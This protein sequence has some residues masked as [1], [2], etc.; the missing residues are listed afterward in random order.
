MKCPLSS[1]EMVAVVVVALTLAD[2]MDQ[3]SSDSKFMHCVNEKVFKVL[4][5][6]ILSSR[7]FQVVVC[8]C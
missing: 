7:G 4:L 2:E 5:P 1:S 3:C 6:I 8:G